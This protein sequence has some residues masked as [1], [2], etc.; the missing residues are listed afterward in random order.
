M[1]AI[2]IGRGVQVVIDWDGITIWWLRAIVRYDAHGTTMEW[3][4]DEYEAADERDAVQ[5]GR[6]YRDQWLAE[7]AEQGIEVLDGGDA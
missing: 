1:K 6:A 4:S 3:D 2:A 7:L 5:Q